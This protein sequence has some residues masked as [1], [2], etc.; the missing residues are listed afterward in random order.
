[1]SL[2]RMLELA[3]ILFISG[4]SCSVGVGNDEQRLP[5]RIDRVID[6]EQGIV[7]YGYYQRAISCLPLR[8]EAK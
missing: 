5:G 3:L 4:C 1:M 7:C 6:R 2:E 8:R